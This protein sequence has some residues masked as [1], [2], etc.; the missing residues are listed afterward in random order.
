MNWGLGSEGLWQ[1][2]GTIGA[3][4]AI[5]KFMVCATLVFFGGAHLFLDVQALLSEI[6][7][8]DG[9]FSRATMCFYT[10]CSLSAEIAGVFLLLISLRVW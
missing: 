10:K 2:V 5:S 4:T 9:L 6:F 7:S 1:V 8:F 3:A